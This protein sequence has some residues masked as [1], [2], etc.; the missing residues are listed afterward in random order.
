MLII[1]EEGNILKKYFSVSS[2]YN[3]SR[4]LKNKLVVPLSFHV[5]VGYNFITI[6]TK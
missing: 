5:A 1:V 6:L 3:L 2:I 4:S